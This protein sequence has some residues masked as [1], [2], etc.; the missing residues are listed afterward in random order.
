M[1]EEIEYVTELQV[2]YYLSDGSH[3]M[4]AFVRNRAEKELITAIQQ[5]AIM[6]GLPLKIK[7]CA[8][9]E[10]SVED[11]L[12]LV[13]PYVIAMGPLFAFLA[14]CINDLIRTYFT[15]RMP[16]G[17]LDLALKVEALKEKQLINRGL[18]LDNEMKELQLEEA[19]SRIRQVENNASLRKKKSNFYN[20][21]KGN[22]TISSIEM[23]TPS[24]RTKIDR[25][26]F[27]SFIVDDAK[28]IDTD[29]DA[30]IAIISPVLKE[31]KYEW[32]GLYHNERISFSM[33]DALFKYEVIAGKYS[34]SNGFVIKARLTIVTIYDDNGEPKR[35]HF[36]VNK[37]Y[38][39]KEAQVAEFKERPLGA[40]KRR[41]KEQQAW[42][43]QQTS[44]LDILDN[45]QER[46]NESPDSNER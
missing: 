13:A 28:S 12:Q 39:T 18:G 30:E 25:S 21:I 1:E 41:Q 3:A 33:G 14:P 46:E 22:A 11:I 10:G 19:R 40:K 6:L 15:S 4:D 8:R 36:S 26:D 42:E 5:I 23:A 35:R 16:Q 38:E 27:A 32:K 37:V 31:G 44:F 9:K 7:T 20:A 2:H 43:Q 45:G 34:F 29:D 24:G 17:I